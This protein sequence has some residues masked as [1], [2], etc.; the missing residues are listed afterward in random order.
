MTARREFLLGTVGLAVGALL[1][2]CEAAPTPTPALAPAPAPPAKSPVASFQPPE[3]SRGATRVD[4]RKSGALGDGVHDDTAA[5]QRAIDAL[6][7][8]GGIVEVPAGTYRIDPLQSVRLR[9]RM[10]LQ[11]ATDAR[12]VAIPNRAERSYVLWLSLVDD[13]EIS[14]GQIIG[15]RNAHMGS[16]GE[17]GHGIQIVGA[18]RVS[19][20]DIRISDCWGD[21]I[22]IAAKR[23]KTG[24]KVLSSDIVIDGV[25][26]TGN[27]R[28]GLSIGASRG[29]R[30]IRSEFS[31]TAGTA[32]QCGIDI[33]PD[34]PDSASDVRIEQC[35]IHDNAAHGIL[36]Y[37]RTQAVAISG[38]TI[39][40]NRRCGIV[41]D[42]CNAATIVDNTIGDN[43]AT[44]VFV[45]AGS[46]HVRVSR[47]TFRN[48]GAH[49]ASAVR[50]AVAARGGRA[51]G[52]RDIRVA[53]AA[54]DVQLAANIFR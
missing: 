13:V 4:V 29:V 46:T 40:R 35:R 3:R 37:R 25:V 38:C 6:P 1:P 27:R 31:H 5:F 32:P 44:G 10:H 16:T 42:G 39:E 49:R 20:H 17:W 12:L 43:G 9:S 15:E 48:N 24:A 21:G 14:G 30:V 41:T 50:D 11:L 19:V 22:S 47:N 34:K 26:C 53:K 54:S 18:S 51:K 28:Q 23:N 7:D 8:A 2:G 33:E 36:A 52:E 45:K